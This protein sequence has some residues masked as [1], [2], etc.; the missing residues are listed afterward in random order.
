V[1]RPGITVRARYAKLPYAR[2]PRPPARMRGRPV[3]V[4]TTGG[5]N[6]VLAFVVLM[7]ASLALA[8]VAQ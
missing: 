5:D 3:R 8:F 2:A 1:I 4:A 6:S 7:L